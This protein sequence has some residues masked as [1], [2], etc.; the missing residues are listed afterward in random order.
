[1]IKTLFNINL[2]EEING[3]T[4]DSRKVE[5]GDLFIPLKGKTSLI[6]SSAE[7]S[8]KIALLVTVCLWPNEKVEK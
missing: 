1:M 2:T 7:N 4:I 5:K 8:K 3:I 6:L